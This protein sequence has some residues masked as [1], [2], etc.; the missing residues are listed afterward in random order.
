M[1][2]R[3]R[4]S[5]LRRRGELAD[6]RRAA[7]LETAWAWLHK[8]RRAIL[9]PGRDKLAGEVEVDE[10]YVGGVAPGKHGRG[11]KRWLLG[12]HQGAVQPQQLDYYL[13][14][15]TFRFNRRGSK[16]RRLLFYR[17]LEQAMQT[18]PRALARISGGTS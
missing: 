3:L 12:T 7:A 16:H 9:R 2:G 4:L 6:G 17:L 18:E 14:E 11:V 1:A 15:F 13:A 5:G 8:F 10:S